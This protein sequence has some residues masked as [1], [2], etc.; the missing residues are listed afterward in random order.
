[1]DN[2]LVVAHQMMRT[3]FALFVAGVLASPAFAAGTDVHLMQDYV[4][5]QP[6]QQQPVPCGGAIR[7]RIEYGT[8]SQGW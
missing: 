1:M 4:H 2:G 6:Q 8:T 3:M 5:T 7:C